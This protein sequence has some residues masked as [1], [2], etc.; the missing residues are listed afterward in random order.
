MAFLMRMSHREC[1][2]PTRSP[3]CKPN[4]FPFWESSDVEDENKNEDD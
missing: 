3:F 4:G 1:C 2:P